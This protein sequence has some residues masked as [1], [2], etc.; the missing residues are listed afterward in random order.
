MTSHDGRVRTALLGCGYWGK[1]LLR[2]LMES[3][4]AQL[5]VVVDPSPAA[6]QYVSS[7]HPGLRVSGDESHIF[8]SDSIDAVV[9]ATPAKDHYRAARLA[10][11]A[12]KHAFVEKPLAT[13]AGEAQE[14]VDYA[15]EKGLA[16]MAGHTFLF[17]SAVNYLK[18]MI[19]S[20]SLG[21]VRYVYSRRLNLGIVRS[22]VNVLWN[23]AP[24]DVSIIQYWL[25]SEPETVSAV[26]GIYLQPSLEDVVFSTLRFREGQLANIH[27]S[28]LDPHKVR[29]VTVV[30][31]RKMVVLDDASTEARV[32]IYDM[33]VDI[34]TGTKDTD[35][36]GGFLVSHRYGDT[37]IP[38]IP[39][40]EP[41]AREMAH[42]LDCVRLGSEPISGGQHAVSVVRTI[43]RI[44]AELHK[45]WPA[46][47]PGE[48]GRNA[49]E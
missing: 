12:G 23:L 4:D 28:W 9:I 27:L 2:V 24:H 1:N 41:L 32:V 15:R 13:S 10:L 17:N 46:P 45:G 33:G 18:D 47:E 11:R 49:A 22:D 48:R 38:K 3:R 43:E 37:I 25:E 40:P 36:P 8:D 44:Q 5:L 31:S 34:S 21:D 35:N 20:G 7:R 19:D 14:L 29:T 39:Y 16:L 42:F 6:Q 30:G 26:G